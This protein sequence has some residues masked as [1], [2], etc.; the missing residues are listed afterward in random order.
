MKCPVCEVNVKASLYDDHVESCRLNSFILEEEAEEERRFQ[1]EELERQKKEALNNLEEC[2]HCRQKIMPHE[3]ADHL[4]LCRQ[5]AT[6]GLIF[7]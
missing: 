7:D 5:N 3:A 2:I 1:E 4:V 6:K